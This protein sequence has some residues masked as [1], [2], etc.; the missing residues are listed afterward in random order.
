VHQF[1]VSA[2]AGEGSLVFRT[3]EDFEDRAGVVGESAHDR[4]I[5]L[6]KSAQ[7]ARIQVS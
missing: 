1:V 6:H 7:A 4:V 3:I 2:A 5:D